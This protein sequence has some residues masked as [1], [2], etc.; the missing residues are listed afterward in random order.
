M[1]MTNFVVLFTK[2]SASPKLEFGGKGSSLIYLYKRGFNVPNGFVI[3]SKAFLKLVEENGLG[4]MITK[5]K[6]ANG[7]ELERLLKESRKRII[8]MRFDAD[9]TSAVKRCLTSLNATRVVVRSSAIGEDSLKTSFAGM[10]DTFLGVNAD[11][12]DVSTHIKRCWASLMNKRAIAYR[13][14]HRIKGM[15]SIAVVVQN[16]INAD[17][18]GVTFTADPVSGDRDKMIIEA[19]I[20]LG[21]TLVSGS[22]T[23]DYYVFEKSKGKVSKRILGTKKMV[24]SIKA[25]RA[26]RLPQ[27]SAATKKYCL[28]SKA[29][30]RIAKECIKIEKAFGR[31]QDIEW[32]IRKGNLWIV[33]SRAIT[34]NM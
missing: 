33:Q 18:A 31:P 27:G 19:T 25:K 2:T 1:T 4:E 26:V 3:S 6:E 34:T 7:A 15:P 13:K 20:G 16:M 30:G 11:V 10:H 28:D 12:K 14:E 21:E 32:C 5:A 17:V 24:Y 23:P 8:S 9:L 29:V 22:V